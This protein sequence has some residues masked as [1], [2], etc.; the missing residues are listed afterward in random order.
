MSPPSATGP[1]PASAAFSGTPRRASALASCARVFGA[2][3]SI[4]RQICRATVSGSFPAPLSP[5][6]A[7]STPPPTEPAPARDGPSDGA[8]F[9][10]LV[11]T[12]GNHLQSAR[13]RA[14]TCARA[15]S[16]ASA[17]AGAARTGPRARRIRIEARAHAELLLDLLLDLVGEVRVAAQE[18]PG[19]LLALAELV[20]LVGLPGARL[21]D[22]RL[23]HTQIG[24]AALP[25]DGDT[26][27]NIEFCGLERRAA[28]VHDHIFGN[29]V[30]EFLHLHT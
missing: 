29:Q 22:D 16:G 21:A 13:A 27:Q 2:T 8:A 14:T 15:S 28:V 20:T 6:A 23:V 5:R 30:L 26:V 1:S 7:P 12:A 24:Q 25:A 18:V 17:P 3:A 4:R 11:A 19:V 9:T 10:R